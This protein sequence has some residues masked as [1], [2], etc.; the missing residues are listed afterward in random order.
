MYED[1]NSQLVLIDTI[2]AGAFGQV[3]CYYDLEKKQ[4]SAI[5][6]F[7]RKEDFDREYSLYEYIK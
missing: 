7:V 4:Y 3:N 6:K 2:G 1:N 5:K